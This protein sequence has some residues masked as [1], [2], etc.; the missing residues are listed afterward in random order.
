MS[1]HES[2]GALHGQ[3]VPNRFKVDFDC[4]GFCALCHAEIA[5]FEGSA[6]RIPVA[7]KML[8][9]YRKAYFM[10]ND[11]S[12]VQVSLCVKCDENVKPEDTRRLM[13]SIINGMAVE[14]YSL[15]NFHESWPIE[16][17]DSYMATYSAKTIE[18]RADRPWQLE[19]GLL[20]PAPKKENIK[21]QLSDDLAEQVKGAF[22]AKR[23]LEG[24]DEIA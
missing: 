2:E 21:L 18:G 11:G 17:R 16:K 8:S 6:G 5:E 4:A 13:E 20:M 14:T 7:T 1:Q 22:N 9:E 3:L 24:K 12:R 15:V 23:R 10:L 19:D